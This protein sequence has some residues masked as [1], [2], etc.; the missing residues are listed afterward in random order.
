MEYDKQ[1]TDFE[2]LN[3]AQITFT[4][5]FVQYNENQTL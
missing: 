2:N 5:S 4:N 3:S 1:I